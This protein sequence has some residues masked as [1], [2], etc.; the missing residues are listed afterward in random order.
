MIIRTM[1]S[2]DIEID[3]NTKYI[4]LEMTTYPF[5]WISWLFPVIILPLAP[6]IWIAM[7]I[8]NFDKCYYK[9]EIQKGR[10][11]KIC[12]LSKKQYNKMIEVLNFL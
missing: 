11:K 6:L 1:D 8:A 3:K 9:V 2:G 12:I 5:S 7:F 10:S 4:F